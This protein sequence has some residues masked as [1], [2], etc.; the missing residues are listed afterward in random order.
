METRILFEQKPIS[1]TQVYPKLPRWLTSSDT[2]WPLWL[3][4]PVDT[5]IPLLVEECLLPGISS[6]RSYSNLD[7]MSFWRIALQSSASGFAMVFVVILPLL[8]LQVIVMG[9]SE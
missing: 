4:R 5:R 2:L 1:K 7:H 9:D 6:A 3:A 8:Q